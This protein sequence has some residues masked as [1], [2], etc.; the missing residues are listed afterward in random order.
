MAGPCTHRHR[1]GS[2]EP[3]LLIHGIGSTW[4]VWKPVLAALEARHD[5]LALSLPGY[6]ESPPLEREPTVPALVDAVE[7]ELDAEGWDA[8]HVAGNSLG[9]WIAAELAARG[10]ARSAVALSPAGLWTRKEFRYS[11]DSLRNSHAIARKLAPH[12]DLLTRTALG[13]TLL[14]GQVQARP[15]GLDPAEAAYAL[16]CF[17]GS[18]SFRATLDWVARERAQPAGLDRIRCPFRVVW[19][20]WDALLPLRQAA[21]WERLIPGAELVELPRLGH[22]PMADDPESAAQAIL[23]FTGHPREPAIVTAAG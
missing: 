13:R 5:V 9:G 3:L 12:A 16:Q 23:D 6:G 20:T 22:V 17:A 1:A 19:G 8:P 4:R 11:Y 21:R 7:E 2:G 15:W 14:F 18:P 10:R